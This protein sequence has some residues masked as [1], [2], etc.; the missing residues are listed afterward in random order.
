MD[1]SK[2]FQDYHE[3]LTRSITSGKIEDMKNTQEIA[4]EKLN[5]QVPI[6]SSTPSIFRDLMKLDTSRSIKIWDFRI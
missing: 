2:W 1:S 3:V 5:L 6:P 4:Q